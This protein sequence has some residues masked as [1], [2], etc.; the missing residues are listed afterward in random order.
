MKTQDRKQ[1]IAMVDVRSLIREFEQVCL[2]RDWELIA[3]ESDANPEIHNDRK[4]SLCDLHLGIDR[5]AEGRANYAQE[6]VEPGILAS[7][8]FFRH[9]F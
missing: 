8:S 9:V 1:T 2:D 4:S 5:T 3:G 7:S 6:L